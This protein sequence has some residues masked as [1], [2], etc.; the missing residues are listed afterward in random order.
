MSEPDPTP[1]ELDRLRAEVAALRERA[2]A[3]EVERNAAH[4]REAATADVL[5]LLRGSR[6]EPQAVLDSVVER[7][8]VDGSMVKR[9][10]EARQV[11]G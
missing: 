1:S 11:P 9:R 3:A 7:A 5:R 2:E 10:Y 6:V 4:A 8:A